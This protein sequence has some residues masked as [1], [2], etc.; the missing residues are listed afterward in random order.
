VKEQ[1]NDIS[2]LISEIH[3]EMQSMRKTIDSQHAEICQLNR[4]SQAQ[5]KEIRKL[6]SCF[7][8]CQINV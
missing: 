8:L 5:L 1:V 6:R 3:D 2:F 4:N 7:E